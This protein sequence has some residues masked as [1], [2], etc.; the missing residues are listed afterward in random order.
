MAIK[1]FYSRIG[2]NMDVVQYFKSISLSKVYLKSLSQKN[3]LIYEINA[4]KQ[5]QLILTLDYLECFQ[6]EPN[7]KN[8]LYLKR[9]WCDAYFKI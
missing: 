7:I 3:S 6:S 8:S 2:E 5:N 1:R 4:L 9:E